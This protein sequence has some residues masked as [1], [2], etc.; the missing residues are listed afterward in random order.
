[1]RKQNDFDGT[2]TLRIYDTKLIDRLNRHYADSGTRY[3]N[4]N[5]LLC[6]LIE[7]GLNRREYEDG[8]MDKLTTADAGVD[9][10]LD[11]L[12]VRME[13]LERYV[14]TRFDEIYTTVML[15]QKLLNALYFI[16]ESE[17][18]GLTVT[19]QDLD[20]GLCDYLP[21]RFSQLKREMESGDV[22]HE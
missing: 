10:R 22:A 20:S 1:M 18:M 16:A 21:I 13:N 15:N 6:E 4:K 3:E 5:H 12:G 14:L 2:R 9:A 7:T 19:E 11:W 8:L 17:V